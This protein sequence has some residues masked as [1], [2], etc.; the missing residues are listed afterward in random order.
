MPLQTVLPQ[1]ISIRENWMFRTMR[2]RPRLR[3]FVDEPLVLRPSQIQGH[4]RG[5]G[6][7]IGRAHCCFLVRNVSWA[8]FGGGVLTGMTSRAEVCYHVG[9]ARRG[10]KSGTSMALAATGP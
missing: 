9:L 1:H 8:C 4:R 6:L 5:F 2:T 3:R 7:L 10:T